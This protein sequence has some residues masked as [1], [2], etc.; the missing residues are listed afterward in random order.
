VADLGREEDNVT[1]TILT[2]DCRSLLAA[3]EPES[4]DCCV[5]SPPYWRLRAYGGGD[6]EIGHEE[7]PEGYIAALVDVLEAVRR[8]L[9]PRGTLWL[10]IGDRYAGS[11]A[12]KERLNKH[13]GVLPEQARTDGLDGYKR[14]DLMG[15][16][17]QLA[18]ALRDAGWYLRADIIWHKL[19]AMPSPVRDRRTVA[20][21][22]VFMLSKGESYHYDDKAVSVPSGSDWSAPRRSLRTV[23]SI[24]TACFPGAHFAVMPTEIAQNAI[25]A[26]CPA[27]GVV[28]DPF[29]GAGTVGLVAN[30]TGRSAVLLELNPE[31]AALS[32]R[33][34]EDDG[35]LLADV[36]RAT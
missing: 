12:G 33:R 8:V 2:G 1:V 32:Q 10:N 4:V 26:G 14:K 11:Y 35:P 13:A 7:T 28:L 6:A 27:G 31:Y 29:G 24:P 30:R 34:I 3:M 16:P 20:H 5:T 15:L 19:R 25:L 17:W 23:W 21:E 9:K 18:F 22:Y 36:R